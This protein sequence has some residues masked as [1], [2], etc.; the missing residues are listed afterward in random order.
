[1]P[2]SHRGLPIA[3]VAHGTSVGLPGNPSTLTGAA[4]YEFARAKPVSPQSRNPQRVSR[5]KAPGSGGI[6]PPLKQL[7]RTPLLHQIQEEIKSYVVSNNLKAGD[8]LPSEGDL[9]RQ[10]G[11][12]RNSVREAVKSL[13]VLGILEARAGSGLF[14]KA[15]TFDA[16]IN[17]LP[18]GLLSD[19]NTV[20]N[21]AEVRARLE[22]G[23][24]NQVIAR[25]SP[26]QTELLEGIVADMA[27]A[28]DADGYAAGADRAFHEALYRNLDNPVLMSLLDVF[29]LAVARATERSSVLDPLD[30]CET[31][32]SHR[33]ILDAL[34][35]RSPEQM[36]AAF[37]YHYSRWQF[38]LPDHAAVE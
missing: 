9:A 3:G 1:M 20:R 27:D 11:I 38:R 17:N 2:E 37:D 15:F 26:E 36:R 25:L 5:R 31:V 32:E 21:M 14:V 24:V 16:I 10:L 4:D 6:A 35:A 23:L 12:G 29:W 34:V 33:R 13:E 30:P 18:Y 19:A 7:K 28:A 22:Y 8:P